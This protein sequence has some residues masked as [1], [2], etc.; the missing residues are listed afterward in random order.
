M[1]LEYYT[2]INNNQNVIFEQWS[3]GE[4]HLPRRSCRK[5]LFFIFTSFIAAIVIMMMTRRGTYAMAT[6]CFRLATSACGEWEHSR[7]TFF[8]FFLYFSKFCLVSHFFQLCKVMITRW[9]QSCEA[10]GKSAFDWLLLG[11]STP[12]RFINRSASST[13]SSESSYWGAKYIYVVVVVVVVVVN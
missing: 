7:W 2:A 8:E 12:L 4:K 1:M 13:S 3:R 5:G 6:T 10:P 9:Q 11:P